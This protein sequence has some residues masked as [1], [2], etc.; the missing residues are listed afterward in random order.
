MTFK[1]CLFNQL[2]L[3]DDEINLVGP[4]GT[5]TCHLRDAERA[6]FLRTPMAH[7]A[8][9]WHRAGRTGAPD[10]TMPFWCSAIDEPGAS[11]IFVRAGTVERRPEMTAEAA[12]WIG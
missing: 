4:V 5:P 6:Q 2:R 12:R 1:L 11:R 7:C 8:A 10:S 3:Q 9:D